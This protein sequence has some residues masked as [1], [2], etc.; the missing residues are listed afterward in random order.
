MTTF[1]GPAWASGFRA[2]PGVEP[3]RVACEDGLGLNE[4]ASVVAWRVVRWS[5]LGFPSPAGEHQS[6]CR[7]T[8]AERLS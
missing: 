5:C 8:K 7:P 2:K 6:A 3:C 1:A 4:D